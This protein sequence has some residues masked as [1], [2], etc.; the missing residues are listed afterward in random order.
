MKT[1]QDWTVEVGPHLMAVLI[2]L[3]CVL[4]IIGLGLVWA[5]GRRIAAWR[6]GA[7]PP[8]APWKHGGGDGV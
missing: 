2:V 5:L 1:L 4:A 3:A 8:P 7:Q 6:S